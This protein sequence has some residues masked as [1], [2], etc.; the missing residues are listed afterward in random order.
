MKAISR[1]K[2]MKNKLINFENQVLVSLQYFLRLL[3]HSL[4]NI[5]IKNVF[6]FTEIEYCTLRIVK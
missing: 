4:H 5:Y 6:L 1:S 3:N 2:Q